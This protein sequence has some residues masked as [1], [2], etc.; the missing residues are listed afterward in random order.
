[1]STFAREISRR[2]SV[3]VT[4]PYTLPLSPVRAACLSPRSNNLPVENKANSSP[5]R[6]SEIDD[7]RVISRTKIKC[8]PAGNPRYHIEF[9]AFHY[10]A[11]RGHLSREVR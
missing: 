6:H 4:A 9:P 11:Q 5:G 10:T 8:K 1:M 7:V 2:V 3:I